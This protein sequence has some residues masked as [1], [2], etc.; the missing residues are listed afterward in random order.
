[1]CFVSKGDGFCRRMD[2]AREGINNCVNIVGDVI[3]RGENLKEH[4]C[5]VKQILENFRHLR[6]TINSKK[7]LFTIPTA[8]LSCY[9]ISEDGV[10]VICGRFPCAY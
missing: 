10:R 8:Y 6:I 2:V 5:R 3:I 1:M 9:D 7:F 4:L